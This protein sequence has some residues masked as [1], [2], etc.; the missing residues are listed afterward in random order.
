M[1]DL[2]TPESHLSDLAGD[3]EDQLQFRTTMTDS[4]GDRP[5]L[6]VRNPLAAD[7]NERIQVDGGLFI[8]SWGQAICPVTERQ[9]AVRVIRRVLAV[10][11]GR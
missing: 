1:G 6:I 5:T 8:W 9:T 7:L 10:V 2:N 4:F 11:E 3:L